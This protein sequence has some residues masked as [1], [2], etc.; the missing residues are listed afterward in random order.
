MWMRRGQN[1]IKPCRYAYIVPCECS[2]YGSLSH[3]LKCRAPTKKNP[4]LGFYSFSPKSNLSSTTI[5]RDEKWRKVS[6]VELT[7][8]PLK[9]LKQQ[10]SNNNF[11]NRIKRRWTMPKK[12]LK[13]VN[14]IHCCSGEVLSTVDRSKICSFG[15]FKQKW[16][17][18]SISLQSGYSFFFY[19][20]SFHKN[21]FFFK[22]K[23]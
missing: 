19:S 5:L 23:N 4:T 14:M 11:L 17:R 18:W 7:I 12:K 1:A 9:A 20:S 13:I 8:P 3:Y 16:K 2:L 21:R 10:L 6:P 15:H 22:E